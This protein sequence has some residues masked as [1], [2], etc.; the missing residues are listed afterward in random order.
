MVYLEKRLPTA[1]ALMW[2]RMRRRGQA[3]LQLAQRWGGWQPALLSCADGRTSALGLGREVRS[4]LFRTEDSELP[5]GVLGGG[6]RQSQILGIACCSPELRAR[7]EEVM[8]AGLRL[9]PT[10]SI[11]E[12]HWEVGVLSALR[13]LCAT[14]PECGLRVNP[15]CVEL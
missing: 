1:A 14:R 11:Q 6:K 7:G 3:W 9:V 2:A 12:G 13:S 10:L 4:G 8:G 5:A 15:V